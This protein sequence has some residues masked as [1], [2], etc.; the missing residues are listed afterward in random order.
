MTDPSLS[1]PGEDRDAQHRS[2][3]DD[4]PESVL[5]AAAARAAESS[6][7]GELARSTDTTS[8]ALLSAVGGVRGL[9]ETVV[10]SLVFL[11]LFTFTKNVPLSIGLSVAAA[12]IL[13]VWRALTKTPLT[14]AIAGL[15]GVGISAILALIT[16]R[17][18]DNFVFGL[19]IDAV[20]GLVFALSM[21]VQWPIVGVA[22]GYL[23]GDGVAWRGVK[24]QRRIMQA[25]TLLWVGLFAARLI[26]QTP[27]YLA[28]TDQ[29]TSALAL[30]RLLMGIPLYVPLLLVTWFVVR[31][32]FP[33][34]AEQ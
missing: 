7:L 11:V 31:A 19:V 18:A 2:L 17:G 26:V 25:L 15:I 30:A 9:I 3:G 8:A 33:H 16:G 12:I 23:M 5:A 24:S 28:G 29:A 32:R 21:V 22:A 13:T 34:R 6:A 4:A 20:Y 27:L 10:P 14:Q 1:S